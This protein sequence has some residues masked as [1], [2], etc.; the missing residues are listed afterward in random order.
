MISTWYSD[1][2]Q[3]TL[4]NSFDISIN[5]GNKTWLPGL[6]KTE[7]YKIDIPSK[8]QRKEFTILKFRLAEQNGAN[9]QP[10]HIGVKESIP[11]EEG[12]IVIGSITI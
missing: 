5:S 7:Q 8:K 11:D 9:S 10:V 2:N 1:L 4:M 6:S 3:K 12:F